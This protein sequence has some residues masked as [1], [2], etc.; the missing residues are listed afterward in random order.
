VVWSTRHRRPWLDPEWRGRLFSVASGLAEAGRARLLCAGGVRDHLHL[1]LEVAAT[2]PLQALV[3]T[4][5]GGT[6]RWI[7]STFPHR[8]AFAWQEGWAGFSVAPGEDGA[9]LDYIRH[10]EVRHRDHDFAGEYLGLLERHG[11][12]YDLREVWD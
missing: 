5:K 2:E 1:Y 9:L 8:A 3:T 7:R 6:A 10:Q 11:I 12:A 4:L